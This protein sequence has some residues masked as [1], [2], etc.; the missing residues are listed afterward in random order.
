[1]PVTVDVKVPVDGGV[2]VTVV[3]TVVFG[4]VVVTVE[5]QSL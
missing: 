5:K 2:V 4:V 1:V 3:I